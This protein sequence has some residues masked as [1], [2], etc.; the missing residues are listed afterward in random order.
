MK[1][2]KNDLADCLFV[3]VSYS[4]K[5]VLVHNCGFH[6]GCQGRHKIG[7]GP[8]AIFQ[9]KLKGVFM[10]KWQTVKGWLKKIATSLFVSWVKRQIEKKG[11][12]Y[13]DS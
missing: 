7:H 11:G 12:Q 8:V 4:R 6:L 13:A 5:L 10:A 3:A 1:G 9:G 2:G